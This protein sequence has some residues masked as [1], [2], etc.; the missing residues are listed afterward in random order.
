MNKRKRG[1]SDAERPQGDRCEMCGRLIT[2]TVFGFGGPWGD[3]ER[4]C[5]DCLALVMGPGLVA[6]LEQARDGC[7]ECGRQGHPTRLH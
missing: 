2:G 7:A 6:V 4:G 5:G 3:V 1:R